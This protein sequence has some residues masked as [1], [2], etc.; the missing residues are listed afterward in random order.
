MKSPKRVGRAQKVEED[1]KEG[2]KNPM[3]GRRTQ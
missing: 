2:K 3:R 1:P